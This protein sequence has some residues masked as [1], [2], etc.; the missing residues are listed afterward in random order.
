MG[1]R[2]KGERCHYDWSRPGEV[3]AG[4]VDSNRYAPGSSRRVLRATPATD[5]SRIE[6]M[7]VREFRSGTRGRIFGAL[8]RPA[9][10]RI[11]YALRQ[12]GRAHLEAQVTAPT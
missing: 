5:G 10:Q 8:F 3:I 6:M 12:E 4:V 2:V 7:W 1:I 9:D 11:S